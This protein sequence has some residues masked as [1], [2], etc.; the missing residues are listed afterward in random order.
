MAERWKFQILRLPFGLLG[1]RQEEDLGLYGLYY[2]LR[3]QD[4]GGLRLGVWHPES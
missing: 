1:L 2:S 4:I 3:Y